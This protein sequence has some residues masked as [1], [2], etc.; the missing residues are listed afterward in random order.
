MVIKTLHRKVQTL[1]VLHPAVKFFGGLLVSLVNLVSLVSLVVLVAL[2]ELVLLEE[3]VPI[4]S[5]KPALKFFV[6]SL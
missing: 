3:L 2:V 6:F 4:S 1:N 5:A